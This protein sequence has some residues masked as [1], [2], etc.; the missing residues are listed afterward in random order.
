MCRLVIAQIIPKPPKKTAS[1]EGG[2]GGKRGIAAQAKEERL[3]WERRRAT[4]FLT[5]YQCLDNTQKQCLSSIL[6]SKAKTRT[7][8]TVFLTRWTQQLHQ[9]PL[10]GGKK[11]VMA[12]NPVLHRATL[13][14]LAHFPPKTTGGGGGGGS[15]SG[16]AGTKKP[17]SSLVHLENLF[18]SKDKAIRR[19]LLQA[20]DPRLPTPSSRLSNV[21]NAVVVAA[22]ISRACTSR[23]IQ[24]VYLSYRVMTSIMPCDVM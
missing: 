14:L 18:T 10:P 3:L 16:V 9:P 1:K 19:L 8:L 22:E 23:Y 11:R 20:I 12:G 7:E 2:E 21:H 4:A 5:M 6:A 24:H 17:G 13:R 15:G